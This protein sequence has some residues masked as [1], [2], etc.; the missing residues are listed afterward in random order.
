MVAVEQIHIADIYCLIHYPHEWPLYWS[1]LRNPEYRM[2]STL[3]SP[4]QCVSIADIVCASLSLGA[5]VMYCM[6]PYLSSVVYSSRIV[7]YEFL[8]DDVLGKD[9][10]GTFPLWYSLQHC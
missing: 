2:T 9:P 10:D 3:V 7:F 5:C 6:W 1:V 4:V 8:R